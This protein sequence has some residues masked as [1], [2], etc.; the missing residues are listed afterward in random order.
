M[1]SLKFMGLLIPFLAVPG[2]RA[3]GLSYALSDTGQTQCYDDQGRAGCPQPGR[4]FFG[5]DAQYPGPQPQYRDNGDGTVSDLVTGLMWE[6]AFHKTS[7]SEAPAQ[8][9][10]SRTGGHADWRVPNIKE[11]YS[12]MNFQGQTGRSGPSTQGAP[13]DAK[14][15]LNTRYFDFEYPS[16]GRFID[17]QYVTQTAYQGMTMGRD[18][19]FFGVN[20]ADGRIKA[21]PQDGG[22]GGRT[23]YARY[24]RGN[25]AYGKN[26]FKNN[27]DGTVSD[28]ATGLTWMQADSGRKL[29]WGQ[30][31]AYCE[32]LSF[33][34]HDDWRL[35]NAKELH[36]IVDYKRSPSATGSAAIDP[37]FSITQIRDEEG[38]PDWPYFWTSTSHLDGRQPGDFAVYIAFGRAGGY[39]GV[40]GMMMGGPP[41]MGGPPPR[42]GRHGGPPPNGPMMGGS[43]SSNL[44]LLDVHG[45][46][47]QRS[48]P[49]SGDEARLPK[50]AGPQGDVLRIYNF[51][52]CVRG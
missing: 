9:A 40:N 13:A 23:W 16:V 32:S 6:K 27:G 5:Q 31:L 28:L 4:V 52:R 41:G 39:M 50:G 19:S 45:A 42:D 36:S 22:P 48:S 3:D 14:P 10:G 18:K 2:A 11:L 25:P 43:S 7:F 8:A 44:K 51:A 12:L 30:A 47:A 21:Y 46:G 20:F 29:D 17:A 33:A 35:P 26:D 38:Q 37:V 15:Y 49:K 34:G 1:K 24:V